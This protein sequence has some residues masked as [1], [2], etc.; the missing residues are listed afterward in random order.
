M[1]HLGRR[2]YC[3]AGSFDQTL[4]EKL[5][6]VTRTLSKMTE[7]SVFAGKYKDMIVNY[8]KC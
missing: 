8:S 2:Q 3:L 1:A 4:F 7:S 6:R 5:T